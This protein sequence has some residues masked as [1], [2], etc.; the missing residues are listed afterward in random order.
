MNL[1]APS[2][3]D[4]S[5]LDPSRIEAWIFD[6]DNTLYPARSNLFARVS[7]R[8]TRFV[9]AE[10]SLGY[11]EA[12]ALQRR[13]FREH[14]TTLRGLMTEYGIDGERFL[15]YVHDVDLSDITEDA[16]L[17][18]AIGR[19]PG[20]KIVFTNGSVPHAR[21]IM[22]RI[23]IDGHFEDVFDIVAGDFVP[24]P[25]PRPY[26]ALVARSGLVPAN[27]VMIEDMARNLEPAAALGMTT[28]WL[29]G[30]IDWAVEGADA[31]Y[32]HHVAD[33]LTGWL[34]GLGASAA[35]Y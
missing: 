10:F 11:E 12:R 2:T 9:E 3:S 32:V 31:D 20:R 28:V 8:M 4:R 23:G 17:S 16:A 1:N 21:R 7:Q 30:D 19:L 5:S 26:A 35:A 34:N 6:L 29:K 13:L 33:D 24:K 27:C 18:A 25:D 22:S 14:G 15:D